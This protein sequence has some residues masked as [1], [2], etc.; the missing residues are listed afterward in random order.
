MGYQ[1][2]KRSLLPSSHGKACAHG[3]TDVC[4]GYTCAILSVF[5]FFTI[6]GFFTSFVIVGPGEVAI[7]IKLGE[8]DTLLPGWHLR[9]PFLTSIRKMSTKIQLLE[10]SNTIPTK[11]GLSVHLDTAM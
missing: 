9:T 6:I 2:D 11:E 10:E 7:K 4:D 5:V 3:G 1:N 8:V